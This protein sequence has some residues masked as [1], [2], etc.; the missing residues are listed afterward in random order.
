LVLQQAVD[1]SQVGQE[2]CGRQS[3]N[4][5]RKEHELHSK[6]KGDFLEAHNFIVADRPATAVDF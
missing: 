1:L 2:V 6:S 5:V 3:V 4:V